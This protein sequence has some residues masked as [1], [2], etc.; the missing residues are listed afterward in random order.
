ML[1]DAAG[2]LVPTERDANA[3][4][5]A[6]AAAAAV[7]DGLGTA[8]ARDHPRLDVPDVPWSAEVVV[9]AAVSASIRPG[10]R[11]GQIMR[12]PGSARPDRPAGSAGPPSS[13]PPSETA[14]ALDD[15]G[16]R[17]QDRLPPLVR[18]VLVRCGLG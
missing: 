5:G 7:D 16:I 8:Y 4:G 17:P 10:T 14:C 3:R 6:C 18:E 15:R 2:H 11:R 13:P 9:L 1:A 12:A